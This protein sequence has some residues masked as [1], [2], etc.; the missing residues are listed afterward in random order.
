MKSSRPAKI[1]AFRSETSYSRASALGKICRS[2]APSQERTY[3]A[4]RFEQSGVFNERYDCAGLLGFGN[5]QIG[6]GRLTRFF[7][8]RFSLRIGDLRRENGLHV[9]R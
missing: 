8:L 7:A 9:L 3:T 2:R 5:Q 1:I 6:Q 4:G